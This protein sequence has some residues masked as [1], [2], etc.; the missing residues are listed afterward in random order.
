MQH[1]K[2]KVPKKGV[3]TIVALLVV[4]VTAAAILSI[5]ATTSSA[6]AA[7]GD[8]GTPRTETGTGQP[9]DPNCWGEINSGLAQDDFGSPGVGQHASN[10]DPS[11]EERE[12]P[13]LGV[14]NQPEGHPSDHAAEVG[15]QFG[16][17][18]EP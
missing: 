17:P 4:A 13:R 10:P 11:D 18:C 7:R 6:Y 3:N 14:G 5:G 8:H 2:E 15:P 1:S 9:T 16:Q 12:T